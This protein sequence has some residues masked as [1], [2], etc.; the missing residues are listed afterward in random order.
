MFARRLISILIACYAFAFAIGALAAV[1]WP[2]IMMAISWFSESDVTGGLADVDW[3]QLGIAIGGPYMLAAICFYASAVMVSARRHGAVIWFMMAVAAGFS[4]VFIV[5]FEPG[6]WQD[7]SAAEGAVAGAGVGALL[8]AVAVWD[9]RIK[10]RPSPRAEPATEAQP[11]PM[12]PIA[13]IAAAEPVPNSAIIKRGKPKP[14]LTSAAIMRQRQSFIRE[15]RK[16]QA[17][18]RR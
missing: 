10:P 15:G 6:W 11:V 7:P 5:D 17:R 3:R 8:L 9:L 13:P 14:R 16:M 1:R 18:K 2:S 4:C 12:A